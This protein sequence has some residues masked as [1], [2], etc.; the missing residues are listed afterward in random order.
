[1]KP[2]FPFCSPVANSSKLDK[3]KVKYTEADS[4]GK[5]KE[6]KKEREGI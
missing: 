5:N 4:T 1:M 3:V 2:H 6:S